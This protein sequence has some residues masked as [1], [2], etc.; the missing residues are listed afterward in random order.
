MHLDLILIAEK[1]AI[2]IIQGF[3]AICPTYPINMITALFFNNGRIVSRYSAP[4][5]IKLEPETF[6]LLQQFVNVEYEK[7]Q[8]LIG[9]ER[10]DSRYIKREN[11]NSLKHKNAFLRIE[12]TP[13]GCTLSSTRCS[14]DP[15]HVLLIVTQNP[16]MDDSMKGRILDM[17]TEL[18][19]KL[20][21]TPIVRSEPTRIVVFEG[22]IHYVV[23]NRTQ[24]DV[25]ELPLDISLSLLSEYKSIETEAECKSIFSQ[26][27]TKLASYSMSAMISGHTTMIWGELGYQFS[28]E[29]RV[30]DEDGNIRK[31]VNVFSHPPFEDDNGSNYTLISNSLF[32]TSKSRVTVYE[33]LPIFVGKVQT[34]STLNANIE[35]MG[36]YKR[37]NV[38]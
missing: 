29:M 14:K 35:I 13:V 9:S 25:F 36:L 18:T 23:I 38:Y 30:E 3:S 34:K 21:Q 37:H 12:R 22:L 15:P 6:S 16:K 8:N 20:Y 10:F 33:I 2:I 4:N 32:P 19:D 31:P 5:S 17:M 28:Y 11:N 24:G 26:L 1:L 7:V 27:T